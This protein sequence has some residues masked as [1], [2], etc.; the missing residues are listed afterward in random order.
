MHGASRRSTKGR[1][2]GWH[3]SIA[4]K[5]GL[6]EAPDRGSDARHRLRRP[7]VLANPVRPVESAGRRANLSRTQSANRLVSRPGR[8]GREVVDLL[9]RTATLLDAEDDA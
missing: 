4:P 3:H 6:A 1:D 7:P 9:G 2:R 5:A 8:S